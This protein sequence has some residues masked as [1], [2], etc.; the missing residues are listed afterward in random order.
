MRAK[1]CCSSPLA[2][3]ATLD[4]CAS[5]C[6]YDPVVAAIDDATDGDTIQVGPGTY[7]R[8]AIQVGVDGTI[9]ELLGF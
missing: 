7:L 6:T 9:G 8:G 5:G 4:V 2:R 1:W 3:A